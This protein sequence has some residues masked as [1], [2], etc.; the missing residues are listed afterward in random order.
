MS[1][2]KNKCKSCEGLE[3]SW[4]LTITKGKNGYVL[5]HKDE[6]GNPQVF[7]IQESDWDDNVELEAMKDVLW[8]ISEY[9]GIYFSKHS[10]INLNITLDKNSD[11]EE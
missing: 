8:N 6:F 2:K 3:Q 11:L 7:V 1:I 5:S 4:S 9:F 10:P